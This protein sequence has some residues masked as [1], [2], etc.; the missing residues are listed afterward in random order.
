[1][2]A[3]ERKDIDTADET[4]LIA[5]AAAPIALRP[6][7]T[8]AA[9]PMSPPRALTERAASIALPILMLALVIFGWQLWV[10]IADVPTYI[11]P[12]PTTIARA[13]FTDWGL[14]W[15]ALVVTLK[16]TATALALALAGGSLLAIFMAQSYWIEIALL[17]YT[18]ILQVTPVVAIAPLI[19]IYAPTTYA[20]LLVVA[21]LVAFFPV[22]SNTAQG[23]KSTDH[24]LLNLF[25]LYGASRWQTLRFLKIPNALPYFLTGLRIAGG[26]AL[27]AA[28]VAEFA[29]GTA[30]VGSGLAYRVLEAQ[31]RLNM[32]RLFAA[33]VLLSLMGV[34]IFALTS[35]VS[36]LLLRKWHESAVR[37]EN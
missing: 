3:V 17:P 1:M 22:L 12:S 2:L 6:L 13:M 20:A 4:V 5:K 9:L 19:L 37:R 30:G 27:I 35:L 16:I 31:F 32:P 14:L 10:G 11:L 8:R 28:V 25:E 23:L 34:V 24:N 21:F 29:A 33:L 36:H 15:P 26:L 18:V 7:A